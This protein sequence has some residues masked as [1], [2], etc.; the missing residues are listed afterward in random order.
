MAGSR[1]SGAFQLGLDTTD[2]FPWPTPDILCDDRDYHPSRILQCRRASAIAKERLGAA[3][4]GHPV[5]LDRD[6]IFGPGE[7]QPPC[8]TGHVDHL[9][10]EYRCRQPTLDHD[11]SR[12]A[13]HRRL[14]LSSSQRE[15][16]TNSDDAAPTGLLPGGTPQFATTARTATQCCVQRGQCPR[17]AQDAGHFDRRP[18]G[19]GERPVSQHGQWRTRTPVHDQPFSRSKLAT[20]WIKDVQI[21]ATFGVESVRRGGGTQTCGDRRAGRQV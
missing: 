2:E 15:Q 16:L 13:F 18:S 1:G 19:R 10:L 6:S 17:T 8:A 5:I 14:R 3:V 11:Q 7:V 4:P 21:D 12:L 9:V 20:A